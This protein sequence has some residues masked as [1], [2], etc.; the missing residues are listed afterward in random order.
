[1]R[2]SNGY[3]IGFAAVLTIVLGGL[4]SLAAVML[5]PLQK[6]EAELETMKQI[7]SAVMDVEGQEKEALAEIY[8]NRIRTYVVDPK[9]EKL[10]EDAWGASR[11]ED[12]D[13]SKEYK[14]RNTDPERMKLPMFEFLAENGEDVEAYILPVY[15]YGLWNNIWGYIAL[16]QDLNTLKGVTFDHVGETPGLGARIT[17][18]EVK[19]RYIGKKLRDEDGTLRS[20]T[21][22]KG[23]GNPNIDDWTVDGMSGATITGNGVN[24]MVSSYVGYYD[25]Y[26]NVVRS[27]KENQLLGPNN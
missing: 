16:D 8:K 12:I 11:V 3:I 23:E 24:D 5:K 17:D 21:M 15:G 10:G 4:L 2:Q 26:F 25:E 1:M 18:K 22:I 7:L 19:D 9:G 13:I 14:L 6:R 20:V 27:V